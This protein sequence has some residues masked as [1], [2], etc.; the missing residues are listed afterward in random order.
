MYMC[1]LY[2]FRYT[3]LPGKVLDPLEVE[4]LPVVSFHLGVGN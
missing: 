1:V 3:H 2:V 4:S